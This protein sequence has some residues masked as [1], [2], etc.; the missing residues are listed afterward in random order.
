MEL[1]KNQHCSGSWEKRTRMDQ[2]GSN[3][4]GRSDKIQIQFHRADLQLSSQFQWRVID[5]DLVLWAWVNGCIM[6]LLSL[7]TLRQEQIGGQYP[8]FSFCVLF[9]KFY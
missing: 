3:G 2:G 4:D 6:D 5:T 1:G 8:K 9:F 7:Q